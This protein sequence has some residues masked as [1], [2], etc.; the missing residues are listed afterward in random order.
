[1]DEVDPARKASHRFGGTGS[2]C[3]F[4][5]NNRWW[6][7]FRARDPE[8]VAP[9]MFILVYGLR[10]KP[11]VARY[12]GAM[13]WKFVA[14]SLRRI[15]RQQGG[16]PGKGDGSFY[17]DGTDPAVWRSKT[18]LS[19]AWNGNGFALVK[20]KAGSRLSKSKKPTKRAAVA[21]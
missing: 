1:M 2:P 5:E 10:T 8:Y 13:K 16:V 7:S 4:F 21:V 18:V 12:P 3:Y 17:I 20:A 19:Y 15:A 9:P 14:P 6:K 11:I